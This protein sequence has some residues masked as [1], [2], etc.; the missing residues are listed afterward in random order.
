MV[1]GL[2]GGAL[3]LTALARRV[4]DA[5]NRDDHRDTAGPTTSATE[6]AARRP[7]ADLSDSADPGAGGPAEAGD[8][9]SSGTSSASPREPG[10]EPYP[11]VVLDAKNSVNLKDP[12]AEA[13]GAARG[14]SRCS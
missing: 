12:H 8:S 13:K 1:V 9:P 14:T 5:R 7:S 3:L 11:L 10:P 4:M 6:P 2:A